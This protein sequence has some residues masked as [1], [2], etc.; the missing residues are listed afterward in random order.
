MRKKSI[1]TQG[2]MPWAFMKK[3]YILKKEVL[4]LEVG[5]THYVMRYHLTNNE[6][7]VQG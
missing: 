7:A 4:F 2:K 6:E 5:L 1:A 3:C